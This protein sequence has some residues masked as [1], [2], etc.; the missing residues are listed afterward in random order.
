MTVSA[1]AKL[2]KAIDVAWAPLPA[3]VGGGSVLLVATEDGALAAVDA[4]QA[5]GGRSRRE[6]LAAFK[7]LAGGT[8]PFPQ[9]SP[10][11][12]PHPF[13]IKWGRERVGSGK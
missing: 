7:Q 3:P 4:T 10:P 11:P 6:R 9:V 13:P 8:W 1:S 12:F 2:G 5:A